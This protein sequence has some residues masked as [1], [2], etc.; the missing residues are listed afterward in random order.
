MQDWIQ[1]IITSFQNLWGGAVSALDNIIGALLVLIIGLII[2]AGL[3]AVVERL[4]RILKLDNLLQKL[5]VEGY[6]EQAGLHLDCS[7]FF[8]K[9]TYWFLVIVFFLA[10]SDILGFYTLSDFLQRVVLYIPNIIV[11]VV[12]MLTAIII[13]HFLKDLVKVSVKGARLRAGNFLGSLTWWTVIVFGFFA[14]LSQLGIAVSIINS[15]ITGFIA[16]LAL[17]GGI[18]F[19]LGGKDSAKGLIEELSKHIEEQR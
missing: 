8:G 5:G 14:A 10:A 13:G 2:A 19:G 9:I 6:V 17:A 18:A 1:I 4:V 3:K 7:K 11:A 12:I 16:M 15:L